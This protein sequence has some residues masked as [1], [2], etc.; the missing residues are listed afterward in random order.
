MSTKKSDLDIYRSAVAAAAA[1]EDVKGKVRVGDVG[2]TFRKEFNDGWFH[3]VVVEIRPGAGESSH[4]DV[5]WPWFPSLLPSSCDSCNLYSLVSRN[6]F[7]LGIFILFFSSTNGGT[8][9][10][11]DR[12]CYYEDGDSEDLSLSQL[13]N[14][15]LL[16]KERKPDDPAAAADVFDFVD[17]EVESGHHQYK[18][19]GVK[20]MRE[21]GETDTG[22]IGN[23]K[24]DRCVVCYLSLE[25]L[26]LLSKH[27]TP[28]PILPSPPRFRTVQ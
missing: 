22:R 25:L 14:L 9:G 24:K 4:I 18:S 27:H 15:A 17:D 13:R 1:A 23:K 10:G 19:S 2:Y 16:D 5:A 6:C 11:R 8:A 26:M 21:G 12:R 20:C 3:G 28:I 7:S